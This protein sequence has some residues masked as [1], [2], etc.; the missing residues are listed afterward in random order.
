MHS[1]TAGL[2][3]EIHL[4]CNSLLCQKRLLQGVAGAAQRGKQK[5]KN[6]RLSSKKTV[7]AEEIFIRLYKHELQCK[8]SPPLLA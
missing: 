4:L 7:H 2:Q 8:V 3:N 6:Y 1:F 5:E